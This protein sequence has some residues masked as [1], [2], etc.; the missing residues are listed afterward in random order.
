MCRD[1]IAKEVYFRLFNF[2]VTQLNMNIAPREA[3]EETLGIGLLDIY[4]FEV[5]E[6]NGFEQLL[7]N[8]TNE[9]LH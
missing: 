1:S 8:Y 5:F 4:G 3:Q 2:L 6:Q 7:I 9:K